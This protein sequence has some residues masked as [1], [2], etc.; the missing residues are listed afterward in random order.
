MT[1]KNKE[2][3]TNTHVPH[4][5]SSYSYHI[6]IR[7]QLDLGMRQGTLKIAAQ[8]LVL[9]G[10]TLKVLSNCLKTVTMA[11]VAVVIARM[12][13]V[14]KILMQRVMMETTIA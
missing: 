7:H 10:P 2:E 8:P 6:S 9:M 4:S 5:T 14:T 13:T 3:R 1:L 12:M 11:A